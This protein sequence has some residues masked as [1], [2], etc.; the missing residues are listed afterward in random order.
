MNGFLSQGVKEKTYQRFHFVRDFVE[1][2]NAN[3]KVTL[4]MPTLRHSMVRDPK[5]WAAGLV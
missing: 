2:G 1:L 4:K 5:L 3:M